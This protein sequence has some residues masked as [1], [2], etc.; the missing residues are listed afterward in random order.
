VEQAHDYLGVEHL[1]EDA[2]K[3]ETRP[4]GSVNFSPNWSASSRTGGD[5]DRP[6]PRLRV[7]RGCAALRRRVSPCPA[8]EAPA[9]PHAIMPDEGE[10]PGLIGKAT[11]PPV[12]TA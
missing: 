2:L 5:A 1:F 4:N 11:D 9:G 7:K 12:G 10:G 8:F 6:P 3:E